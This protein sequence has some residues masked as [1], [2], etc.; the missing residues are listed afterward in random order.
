MTNPCDLVAER[1]ALGE[2]LGELA[3]HAADCESCR[4]V[5]N[6]AGALTAAH[7]NVDP[8]L[9]FSSRMTVGARQRLAERRRFRVAAGLAATV[10]AGALG[11]ALF[12]HHTSPATPEA[13]LPATNT[14]ADTPEAPTPAGDDDLAALATYADIDSSMHAHANWKHIEEPLAPYANLVK[15]V[16]P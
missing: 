14:H 8:G 13:M 10:A 11:V 7:R 1:I 4:R 2:P 12:T 15:G 6:V 5:V 3:E 9:G 16:T